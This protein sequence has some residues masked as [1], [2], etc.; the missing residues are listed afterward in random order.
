MMS[1]RRLMEQTSLNGEPFV[2]RQYER[3]RCASPHRLQANL[4]QRGESHTKFDQ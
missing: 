1:L 2:A 3:R 4:V